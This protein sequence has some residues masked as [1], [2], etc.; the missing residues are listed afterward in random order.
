LE[1]ENPTQHIEGLN[2]AAF[3]YTAVQM[4]RLLW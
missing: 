1:K 2:S 3:I 4:F